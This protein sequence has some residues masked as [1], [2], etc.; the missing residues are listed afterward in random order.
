VSIQRIVVTGLGAITP[1]GLTKD[2]YWQNLLA[3]VS[4]IRRIAFPNE[5]M[6]QY[7]T[8]VAA[9]VESFDLS[10]YLTSSRKHKYFGRA[11]SFALA[12]TRMALEDSGFTLSLDP[13]KGNFHVRGID[14][15]KAGVILGTATG[16]ME[17]LENE[18]QRPKRRNAQRRFSPHALPNHLASAVPGSVAI[19]FNCQG[20]NYVISTSCTSAS[21]AIGNSYR[22]LQG[23]WEDIMITGGA[24]S[25][26]NSTIFNG[27][28][29][30]KAMSS[31]NENPQKACRPF[32]Q[33]RDGFVMGEG[34]GIIILE[35][36]EH[37]LARNAFIYAELVGFGSTAD[38]HHLTVP[39]PEGGALARAI[40]MAHREA[41][42]NGKPIGYINAHGTATQLNDVVETKALK[43]V[44]K[45]RAYDIPISST[46]SM[47]GHLLGAAGG[48]ELIAT[49]M[50]LR[51]GRIPP[52]IN[53][54]CP[55]PACDL[56]YVPNQMREAP[57]ES[58]MSTSLGFGGFNTALIVNRYD[59]GANP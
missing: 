3:G 12:A 6:A 5:N 47:T 34:A 45:K 30:L 26:I 52:T 35:K 24:D 38:A 14:P 27:F 57:L 40:R 32:D 53:Y 4:G 28:M 49:V 59:N 42:G 25:G 56:D 2:E 22:H 8:R 9:P 11:T 20:I 29:A 46:K 15:S 54:E 17:I 50:A 23:G 43:R 1:I 10:D 41:N 44:F 51:Q 16:D 18:F 7:R 21:Q 33:K 36:L 13:D 55:D 37:A 39:D 48:I 31:Q 58:A 19:M